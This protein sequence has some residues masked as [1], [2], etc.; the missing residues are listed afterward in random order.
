MSERIV[1]VKVTITEVSY[2][3]S[4]ADIATAMTVALSEQNVSE[5]DEYLWGEVEVFETAEDLVGSA[6]VTEI[7]T[8]DFESMANYAKSRGLDDEDFDDEVHDCK[9]G[10][11][12][13]N[14]SE[15]TVRAATEK[16]DADPDEEDEDSDDD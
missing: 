8:V 9:G 15:A 4:L 5:P 7:K 16:G 3:P 2:S 1:Y 10:E 6:Q 11:A 14:Q 12:A 13:E